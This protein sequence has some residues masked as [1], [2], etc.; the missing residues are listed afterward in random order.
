MTGRAPTRRLV[1]SI[2]AARVAQLDGVIGGRQIKLEATHTWI[3]GEFAGPPA[4]FPLFIGSLVYFLS[5]PTQRPV[6]Y[7]Y[8]YWSLFAVTVNGGVTVAICRA[9]A[10]RTASSRIDRA[11]ADSLRCWY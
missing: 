5:R 6:G 9:R 2:L 7:W 10:R 3:T 4:L 8:L 11:T 1:R